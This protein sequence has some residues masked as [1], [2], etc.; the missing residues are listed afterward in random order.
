MVYEGTAFELSSEALETVESSR[1]ALLRHLETGVICYGVT[2]GMGAMSQLD[3]TTEQRAALPRH[4]LLG[5]ASGTGPPLPAAVGRGALLAKLVQFVGGRS[6]VSADL[7]V[8]LADRLNRGM[9]P[10]IPS[11]G[12]G[13]AGEIIPLAHVMQT[14]IGEG[15]VIR[16]GGDIG[17]A[18]Q[19]HLD[20]GVEPYDPGVKE[21]LS[22]ISGT[23]V[24]PALAWDHARRAG[25]VLDLAGLVAVSSVE[26]AA[27][28]VDAYSV[29]AASL[30]PDPF[31][32]AVCEAFRAVLSGSEVRRRQRQAPVSFRVTPQV[33][34]VALGAIQAVRVT[35]LADMR[36]N[37]DNPAFFSD[38]DSPVFGRLVN[39]GNFHGAALASAVENLSRA[40]VHV[41]ILSEKRLYRLLDER[42]TGLARQ[43]AAD[44]GLDA[45][46][47]TVHK[48]ASAY[49][50]SL[51][52]LA[53]S[54]SVMQPDSSFG[55]EDAATMIFASLE[56]LGEAVSLLSIIL[57]HEAYVAAVAIDQRGEVPGDGVAAFHSRLRTR[58]P[59]YSGDRPYGTDLDL[60]IEIID[61]LVTEI[62]DGKGSEIVDQ[63]GEGN[64]SACREVDERCGLNDTKRMSVSTTPGSG[65]AIARVTR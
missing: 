19:W 3:L 59:P 41:G 12:F 35:A 21:G 42:A 54:V 56:R 13:M 16:S 18:R 20:H 31:V 45:G 2:T 63:I 58:I 29:D 39:S 57:A 65:A 60:L 43:L 55:Q 64:R 32:A 30:N 52:M 4:T 48:A 51:R 5:R 49:G 22:L 47:V 37:G 34:A 38:S 27:A 50:A 61:E 46:L 9:T 44:P 24:G 10:M 7:C 33:H 1:Q 14:L 15:R 11:R 17:T 40:L 62:V 8:T 36:C 28:P 53:A 25:A 6:G 23:A 26:A